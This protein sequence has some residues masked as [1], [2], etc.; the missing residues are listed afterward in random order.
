VL[1][2]GHGS[3]LEVWVIDASTEPT[4]AGDGT[5]LLVEPTTDAPAATDAPAGGAP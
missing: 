5:W 3:E 4:L 2:D 1:L